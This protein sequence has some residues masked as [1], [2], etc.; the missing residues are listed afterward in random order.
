MLLAFL[1]AGIYA[2]VGIGFAL[3]GMDQVLSTVEQRQGKPCPSW[4]KKL[5]AVLLF[6]FWPIAAGMKMA[7]NG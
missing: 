2:Q 1:V 5:L 6:F 4:E 7:E 3:G